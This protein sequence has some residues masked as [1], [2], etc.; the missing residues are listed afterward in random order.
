M[1]VALITD[2]SGQR[3]PT[4]KADSCDFI[5]CNTVNDFLNKICLHLIAF[6]GE[7]VETCWTLEIA[8]TC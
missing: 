2:P 5:V 8:G 7:R 1:A 4:G 6:S 3:F